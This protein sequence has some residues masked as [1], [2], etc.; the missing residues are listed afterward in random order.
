[1]NPPRDLRKNQRGEIFLIKTTVV[2]LVGLELSTRHSGLPNDRL[3]SADAN[4]IMVGIGTVIV[5]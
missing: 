2:S 3:Q 1:M 5:P 4:L